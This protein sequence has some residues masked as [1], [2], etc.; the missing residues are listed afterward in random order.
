MAQLE[1]DSD[2]FFL[3]TVPDGFTTMLGLTLIEVLS[4]HTS[5]ELYL[6]QRATAAW[7]DDGEV[8]Q[9]VDGK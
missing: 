7:T 8:L 1:A 5:D 6:G 9:L 4:I 3:N 2:R